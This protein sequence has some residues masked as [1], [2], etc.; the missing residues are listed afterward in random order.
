MKTAIPWTLDSDRLEL[1]IRPRCQLTL[2]WGEFVLLKTLAMAPSRRLRRAELLQV[3]ADSGL[4]DSAGSLNARVSRLR[5]KVLLEAGEPLPLINLHGWGYALIEP[6]R[7]RRGGQRN[8]LD[9][10][11]DDQGAL[12]QVTV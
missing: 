7:V 11:Q 9:P 4:S 2:G 12:C 1:V 6:V 8:R 10:G 3:M 5:R